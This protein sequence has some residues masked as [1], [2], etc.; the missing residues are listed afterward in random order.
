MPWSHP[1]S[2]P[3]SRRPPNGPSSADGDASRKDK[4]FQGYGRFTTG[5]SGEYYFRTLKPVPYPGRT[6]HIHF[7]V[8]LKGKD[9]LTTQ[10]YIKGH[11]GNPGDG[12][13]RNMRDEKLRDL[14]TVDFTPI[15]G[16]K[17]GELAAKF[18]IVLG[19]TP[20]A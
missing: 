2:V 14:I 13:W 10:L 17:I 5:S 1:S 19:V 20:E 15:T 7:K 6:P 12:I 16:S 4:N 18:D 8:K 9:E 11:P 3:L